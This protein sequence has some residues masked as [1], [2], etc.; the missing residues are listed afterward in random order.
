MK[1]TLSKAQ[2]LKRCRTAGGLEPLRADCSIEL[3]EGIDADAMLELRLRKWYLDLLDTGPRELVAADNISAM[4]SVSAVSEG[5]AGGALLNMPAMCRRVF[6]V[7]LRG[8]CKAVEVLPASEYDRVLSCQL[9]PFTAA[10]V[11]RPVAIALPGN[12]SGAAPQVM[13]WPAGAAPQAVTVTA[14]IDP[15]EDYY[16][17][18]ER[19]LPVNL[20]EL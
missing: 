3:T 5:E 6:D 4:V 9:N 17:L 1:I 12:T 2:M 7:K 16:T 20:S 10:T 14:A 19:A 18:D 13:A 8:W 15:G 11:E